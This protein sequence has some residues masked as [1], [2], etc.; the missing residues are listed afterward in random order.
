MVVEGKYE[1]LM[2]E[3]KIVTP[4]SY[5]FNQGFRPVLRSRKGF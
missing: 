5:P 1:E 2:N 4:L 3:V